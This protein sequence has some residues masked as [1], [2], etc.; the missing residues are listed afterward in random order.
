MSPMSESAAHSLTLIE[1]VTEQIRAQLA[2]GELRPNQ[3]LLESAL[4]EKLGI[5]RNTLR[6]SFRLLTKEG[7]LRH[8][9]NRGVFV[10]TP[11]IASII[12]IYRVRRVVECRALSQAYP[13]H[14]AGRQM[15]QAIEKAYAA[16]QQSDW[17]TVA[18]ANMEFHAA[19]V[20]LADSE[21]LSTFYDQIA[22]ELRLA[23]GLVDDPEY[24]H[25]PF[26]DQNN[27]LIEL[28]EAGQ[29]EAAAQEL[30]HYL[31]RSERM[32]LALYAKFTAA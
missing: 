30:E 21:R 6:E 2:S 28:F 14:P 12:D 29:A 3:R 24:L 1:K 31:T 26:L 19:V 32:V 27:K 16:Q 23:F 9:S 25:A 4:S 5:S 22:A 7:L 20:A 18:T 11:S 8:E 17:R 13:R 10:A 15:R